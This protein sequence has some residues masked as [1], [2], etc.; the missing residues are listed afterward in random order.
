MIFEAWHR[1]WQPAEVRGPL[2]M[3]VAVG[4]LVV[5]LIGLALLNTH[6]DSNINVHGAWLHVL[7]DLLGSVAAIIGGL[8]IWLRLG[9]GRSRSLGRD[10]A[11]D[12]LL[13]VG[14]VERGD[15]HSHGGDARPR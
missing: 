8:L 15:C 3:A 14:P 5:N 1:L 4:G 13:V 6:R 2:M 11:V 7:A 9:M 12:H 10:L